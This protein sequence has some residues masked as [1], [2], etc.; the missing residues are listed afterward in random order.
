MTVT[1]TLAAGYVFD[2]PLPTGVWVV[3]EDPGTAVYAVTLTQA[4]ESCGVALPA[5]VAVTQAVCADGE[6]P[7][8]ATVVLPAAQPGVT[9]DLTPPPDEEPGTY[10]VSDGEVPV[11]VTATLAAGY[12]FDPPLPTVVWVAGEERGDGGLRGDV[13]AGAGVVCER[14]LDVFV[15]GIWWVDD[16][17]GGWIYDDAGWFDDGTQCCDNHAWRCDDGDWRCHD[18]S[19]RWRNAIDLA[20]PVA[21]GKAD[22]QRR[23]QPSSRASRGDVDGQQHR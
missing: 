20:G 23:V 13:D 18:S 1:A 12:V 21:S 4:P 15:F 14:D 10:D 22:R 19:A 16:D 11:T 3:G 7:S 5:T 8:T 9:Y 17:A 2:P 6:A